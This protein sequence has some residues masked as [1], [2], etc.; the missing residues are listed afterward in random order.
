MFP[1]YF[2][3]LW[4]ISFPW[5]HFTVVF[6]CYSDLLQ[7]WKN[8]TRIEKIRVQRVQARLCSHSQ[9]CPDPCP[10]PRSRPLRTSVPDSGAA[11]ARAARACAVR[12]W[13]ARRAEVAQAAA[14]RD[15]DRER[16]RDKQGSEIPGDRR[17][18]GPGFASL[19]TVLHGFGTFFPSTE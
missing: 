12:G 15:G 18:C 3:N 7:T 10:G 5:F 11:R 9:P 17:V 13:R 4:C 6:N 19:R 2:I 16:Y 1:N 8:R 14:R